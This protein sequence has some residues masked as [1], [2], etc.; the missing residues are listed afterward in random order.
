L[1]SQVALARSSTS[2]TRMGSSSPIFVELTAPCEIV[3]V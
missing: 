1:L 3:P 2:K